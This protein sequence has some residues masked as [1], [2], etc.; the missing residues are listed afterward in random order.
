MP[1]FQNKRFRVHRFR[2]KNLEFTLLESGPDFWNWE[3][4]RNWLLP[5]FNT[6]IIL[7]GAICAI[8]IKVTMDF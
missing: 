2:I 8:V 7:L 4:N 5:N 6:T 3:P 1:W